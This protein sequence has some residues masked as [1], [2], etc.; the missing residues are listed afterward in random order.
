VRTAAA[1]E[2]AGA[3]ALTQGPEIQQTADKLRPNPRDADGDQPQMYGGCFVGHEGLDSPSCVYGDKRSKR[4]VVLFGDSHAMMW[5]PAMDV[6]AKRR[7]WRLVTLAKQGC[8]IAMAPIYNGPL[9]REYDECDTWRERTLRRIVRKEK[10]RLIVTDS[11]SR[12]EYMDGDQRFGPYS[13]ESVRALTEGTA[14][15]LRRLRGTGAPI[16]VMANG[17][18]A[19][20]NVPACVSDALHD[21]EKCAF[22]KAGSVEGPPINKDAAD[23]VAGV[24]VVDPLPVLCPGAKCPAVIGDVLVYRDNN[25]ITATYSRTLGP[26]LSRQLPPLRK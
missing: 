7:G 18:T 9:G 20:T 17:P 26:W 23:R 21:L 10:P 16:V 1:S 6:A 8:T 25:H 15:T 5:G 2:V 3:A 4:T 13:P 11:V 24:D 19:P 12:Y 22:P 14:K